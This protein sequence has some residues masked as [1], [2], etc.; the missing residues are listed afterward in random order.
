MTAA[1]TLD[2]LPFVK[3]LRYL[4]TEHEDCGLVWFLGA[5]C[6]VSSGI[7]TAAGLVRQWLPQLK[8]RETGSEERWEPWAEGQFPGFAEAAG[9]FYGAVMDRLFP[10][11]NE[12]QR[13]IERLTAEKDPGIGYALLALLMC[14]EKFCPQTNV[15]LTTNFD[16]LVQDA[17]VLGHY[18]LFLQTVRRKFDRAEAYYLR[19]IEAD[20]TEFDALC[21][22]AQ[23]L[24][25]LGRDDEGSSLVDRALNAKPGPEQRLELAFYRYAHLRPHR[26]EALSDM[27]QLISSGIRSPGW[28]LSEHL[29]R[30][31]LSC[32]RA[33]AR[34]IADQAPPDR[35]D[36]YEA[37]RAAAE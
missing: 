32:L 22:Y 18:A 16:D 37:W 11:Q 15:V 24:F 6:S 1:P 2:L 13:E 19:A 5:G 34:V 33:F 21:N 3:R 27:S 28:D 23:L 20:P 25:I 14:H 35:M 36:Q 10:L 29:D 26:D 17:S 8:A 31:D 9:S 4:V 12:R 30:A 7:P